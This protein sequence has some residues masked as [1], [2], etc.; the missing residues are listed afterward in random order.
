MERDL[1]RLNGIG[2]ISWAQRGLG[3]IREG[4]GFQ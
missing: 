2:R 4:R 3:E 1:Y